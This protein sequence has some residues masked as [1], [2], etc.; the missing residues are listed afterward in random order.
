MARLYFL[1]ENL[2]MTPEHWSA[3]QTNLRTLGI[4]NPENA[5]ELLQTST[6][7][8]KQGIVYEALFDDATL[9]LQAW[10]ARVA[11]VVGINTNQVTGAVS[12]IQ[13]GIYSPTVQIIASYGG[14]QRLRVLLFGGQVAEYD[15]SLDAFTDYLHQHAAEWYDYSSGS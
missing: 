14:Q 8:D 13:Y 11:G 1:V 12:S 3:L 5:H 15:E 9:T 4:G 7:L 6:R 10:R 2:A